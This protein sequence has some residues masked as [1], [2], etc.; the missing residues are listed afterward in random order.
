[1]LHLVSVLLSNTQHLSDLAKKIVSSTDLCSKVQKSAFPT[2]PTYQTKKIL[3]VPNLYSLVVTE[4]KAICIFW[5]FQ[6]TGCSWIR[7]LKVSFWER[8]KPKGVSPINLLSAERLGHL[9]ATLISNK[10][11]RCAVL[12][13]PPWDFS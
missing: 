8:G 2:Q 3:S 5:A 9:N 11:S 12:A 6:C 4:V 10:H 13:H 1:M 7:N